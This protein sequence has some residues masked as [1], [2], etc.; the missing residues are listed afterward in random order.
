[1]PVCYNPDKEVESE[2]SRILRLEKVEDIDEL[3]VEEI[4]TETDLSNYNFDERPFSFHRNN[5]KISVLLTKEG[6]TRPQ[7]SILELPEFGEIAYYEMTAHLII[8]GKLTNDNK[9]RNQRGKFGWAEPIINKEEQKAVEEA[10]RDRFGNI[11]NII[12]EFEDEP[13][14]YENNSLEAT[15]KEIVVSKRPELSKHAKSLRDAIHSRI[16]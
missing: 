11:A 13:G 15:K 7:D 1:M 16:A 9:F 8:R 10:I 3:L 14:D 12:L 4:P 2:K 5:G 6:G